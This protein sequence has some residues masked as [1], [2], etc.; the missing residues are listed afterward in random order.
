M[1][2][3]QALSLGQKLKSYL[4]IKVKNATVILLSLL[5]LI[6]TLTSSVQVKNNHT[7]ILSVIQNLL[8]THKLAAIDSSF[9]KKNLADN[10]SAP[11]IAL[12][13]KL[14][15]DSLL[16]KNKNISCGSCHIPKKGFS[17]NVN[18]GT[19]THGTTLSRNVPH[20]YN[21]ALGKTFFWDGRATTLE[22]QL[23]MVITSKDELDMNYKELVVRLQSDSIYSSLFQKN[24]PEE[25]ITKKTI[26]KAIISYEKTLVASDSKF[27]KF[28]NGDTIVFNEQEKNGFLL[29]TG[30]ANCIAC[31][32][33]ANLTDNLFH[34]VGVK[35]TDVGRMKIDKVG[36][37]KEFESTPY[38]FFSTFKAFKTPSLR[39]IKLTGPYFHDGSK[40]SIKEVIKFYNK[41]GEN[42]DLTGLAKEIV[43]LNLTEEEIDHLEAF[44]NTF[45]S[46]S[47]NY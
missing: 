43:P 40:A 1:F 2:L 29:F 45:T 3:N 36:M 8:K 19:G 34:N 5:F 11:I 47:T 4:V 35:T 24:F 22:E 18:L 39:N 41:G 31:H 9:I 15:Y 13:N 20:L 42:T 14:F 46:N 25:G 38:P 26:K 21:L 30:K 10:S 23:D 32:K 28:I 7:G 16:S 44:L 6:C 33:G 17:N 27:D 12:G 37:S